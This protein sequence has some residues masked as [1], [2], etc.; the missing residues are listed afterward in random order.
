MFL[1][2]FGLYLSTL[3]PTVTFWDSG[4]LIAASR[5][6]GVTHQ[7]G[8]PLFCIIGRTFGF[9]PL[10]CYA[11]RSNLAS[12]IFAA[13][14]VYILY[15][16]IRLLTGDEKGAGLLAASFAFPLAVAGPFWSQAV[17]SEVYA[18]NAFLLAALVFVHAVA[19]TDRLNAGRVAALTGLV[20]G[21]GI[22]NHESFVLF[23]PGIIVSLTFI[24]AADGR[25]RLRLFL[26]V[27]FFLLVGLSAW[28]YLPIRGGSGSCVNIGHPD[29]WGRF[30]W[31]IKI[32]EYAR[33]AA[34][35]PARLSGAAE[36]IRFAPAALGAAAAGMVFSGTL[37]RRSARLYLPIILMLL[38]YTAAIYLKLPAGPEARFGFG[39][40]FFVPSFMLTLFLMGGA[41][42]GVAEPVRLF[43][44]LIAG[45][46]L[47][48][49]VLLGVSNYR[50]DDYSRNFVAADYGR[51]SLKSA[52]K[53]GALV[54]WGD[55]GAFPLWYIRYVERYRDD[56][57]LVHAPLMT[58]DWYLD[59]T[60][61]ALR[62]DPGFMDAYFLGE[63]VLRIHR[64]LSPGR[65]TAYDYSSVRFLK[66]DVGTLTPRGI[67][68]FEG[69][70]PPG[71]PWDRYVFRGVGEPGFY[72]GPMEENIG[73]IYRYM[74]TLRSAKTF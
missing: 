26:T 21:L 11:Y 9:L 7:P 25:D 6:L 20:T 3:A 74:R 1:G 49:T 35:L 51:N 64:A 17:I 52:G 60:K 68:Y 62:I 30:V 12:A 37:I 56:V 24:P 31:T 44:Y 59:D 39:P 41:A 50:P 43:R 32:G 18:A 16:S 15:R 67:V 33:E 45:S 70:V 53:A 38:V 47:A 10:G 58:Y 57:T 36:N 13:S 2:C 55:N 71:D 8:Y 72:M 23:I 27:L 46:C 34:G 40:K 69:A 48:A 14:A 29:S 28:L 66:L 63:N 61:M 65:T 19:Q 4:E 5:F 73:M 54:T 42:A 22:V